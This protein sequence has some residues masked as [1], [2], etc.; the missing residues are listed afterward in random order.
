MISNNEVLYIKLNWNR[1]LARK[2]TLTKWFG[3]VVNGCQLR[4]ICPYNERI[5]VVALS[6]LVPKIVYLLHLDVKFLLR[7]MHCTTSIVVLHNTTGSASDCRSEGHVFES[8]PSYIIFHAKVQKNEQQTI[9][10][11]TC[12]VWQ[13]CLVW[14]IYKLIW[15]FR[16]HVNIQICGVKLIA[17]IKISV[18]LTFFLFQNWILC[19]FFELNFAEICDCCHT[20]SDYTA[21]NLSKNSV[22][23]KIMSYNEQHALYARRK[24]EFLQSYI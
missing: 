13:D 15:M 10:Y 3:T 24:I 12:D 16:N 9:T 22:Y 19:L 8:Q 5:A 2:A 11:V 21:Q 4:Q 14:K 1:W 18:I 20:F 23:E 17:L 6:R 7:K